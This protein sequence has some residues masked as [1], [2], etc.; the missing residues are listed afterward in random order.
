MKN[1]W[2]LLPPLLSDSFGFLEVLRHTDG[3]GIVD[4]SGD[5]RLGRGHA[6]G[7]GGEVPRHREPGK[8]TKNASLRIC[9]S[10]ADAQDVT[11]GT[12][13]KLL[14]A[15]ARA[16]AQWD[17]AFA[18]FTAGPCGAMIGTD[19][20]ELA[21]AVSTRYHLPAA[22]V[23][24]TGQRTYDIGLSKTMEALAK[25][26]SQGG[27]ALPGT[28]N[29][30][31][32]SSLDWAEEDVQNVG[33]WA[34]SQGYRVLTQMGSHVTSAQLSR[35]GCAQQNL[36]VSASGLAAARYLQGV[37][38]TPYLVA[39][40]FGKGYPLA[41]P[42]ETEEADVLIIAEQL[43]A[44]AIRN[45]LEANHIAKRVDVATFFTLDKALA[46][47]TDKRLRGEEAAARLLQCPQYK[48]ILAD[49]LLR[50]LLQRDCH[51]IDLPHRALNLYRES[52]GISLLGEN[53]ENWLNTVL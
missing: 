40:P 47:K 18:L 45:A 49:P 46:R 39:A 25:L 29:I 7:E 3:C 14:E 48:W 50:P 9:V 16:R 36:V 19:L 27:E 52:K 32:A 8:R 41:A 23:D 33:A 13:D 37:Y 12:R 22:A 26:L 51:W 31:G 53:L 11:I 15:F 35:M 10:G 2:T 38:G 20:A 44:N 4:D 30:L 1:L 6:R 42:P 28:V 43:T 34:E 24:L 21:E 5:F 17:P